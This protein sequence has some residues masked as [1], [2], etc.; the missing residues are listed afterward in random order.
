MSD[1]TNDTGEWIPAPQDRSPINT[2]SITHQQPHQT[3]VHRPKLSAGARFSQ[4]IDAPIQPTPLSPM[5]QLRSSMPAD[6]FVG[7][8]VTVVI[9]GL[10]FV[11]RWFRLG[12]PA[13]ILFD[14]VYY[15][16]DA[17]SVMQYGYEG[18]WVGDDDLVKH[19]VA[20][21]DFSAL[22]TSA[23]WAVH[24]PV[25]KMLIGV[26]EVLF[27]L[28]PFGW[29]FMAMIFGTLMVWLVIRL[30]RRLAKSTL[31]G[32][33]AGLLLTVDGMN[34]VMSRLALLDVFQAFFLLAGVACVAADREHFRNRLANHLSNLPDHNLA[35]KA[36][37]FVFRGW[38]VI[39]GLMFGL[40]CATKWNSI[41]ALAVFG[42]VVVVWSISARSLAGA[43]S[44]AWFG[45][46]SDGI[47]AFISMV[48]VS[49]AVYI[50]SWIPWLRASGGYLR[51]WG[52]EHG[53]DWVVR[54][55]G[56]ALG[57]LWHNQ[58]ETYQFH[59]GEGMATATHS[60]AST[61]W[62]W[63]FMGRTT[64]IYFASVEAGQ[65]GCPG[66]EE[67]FGVI[68]T[69]GTPLLWW[70]G[71][72]ALFAAAVWWLAGMDW[73]FSIAVLGTCSTWIPWILTGRG[74]MFSFYAITMIP[75]MVIGLAL[76]LGVILGPTRAGN[77]R[78]SGAIIVGTFVCLI[79]LNFLYIYPI[80]TGQL[81]PRSH[82][83][84]R[85]WWPGWI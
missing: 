64:G 73:R 37:P 59:T 80:L 65:P 1:E 57:S 67:C 5:E 40:A 51:D 8:V 27:G 39:A 77:R 12:V 52:A 56:E 34:F 20:T 2:Q 4:F 60:Y 17:W 13:E 66:T 74:A 31:I 54:H 72:I 45:L 76:A 58:V 38:L 35:G 63:P 43:K 81:L 28:N 70:A 79:V 18:T 41:Y 62:V 48:V 68:S 36:G 33:L 9:T 14:E 61:P 84:W 75:F 6:R 24:P 53:D 32:G 85:A 29:R 23:S 78:Q 7:W 42:I 49:V 46:I 71:A 25:G 10:A 47:P 44:H 55:F 50:T 83:Y 69:L 21:G 15:A 3:Q 30:T 26:G 82:Y 11:L 22:T 16:K 19:Q